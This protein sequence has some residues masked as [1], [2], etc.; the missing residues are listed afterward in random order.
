[1]LLKAKRAQVSIEILIL[2]FAVL[3]GGVILS[4][5]M[6]K[7]SGDYGEIKGV[8]KITFEAF[9]GYVTASNVSYVPEEIPE[10]DEEEIPEEDEEDVVTET[11]AF[12]LRINPGNGNP[13]QFNITCDNS[14]EYSYYDLNNGIG[15]MGYSNISENNGLLIQKGTADTYTAQATYI[16]VKAIG[17]N[18]NIIVNG[19]PHTVQAFTLE[20]KNPEKPMTFA[21]SH[22]G[23]GSGKFYLTVYSDSG[24]VIFTDYGSNFN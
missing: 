24:S 4:S 2:V 15:L 18:R 9:S 19:I 6:I 11:I 22:S 12:G 5:Q 3:F 13:V 7:D 10:E 17:S 1:M 20:S 21:I 14:A 8:K 23:G 16:R